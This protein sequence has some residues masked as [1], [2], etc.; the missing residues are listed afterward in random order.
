MQPLP[1]VFGQL[2][3]SRRFSKPDDLFF[4][5]QA[6]F[7]AIWENTSDLT[8]LMAGFGAALVET[9]ARKRPQGRDSW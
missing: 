5:I 3:N 7:R 2:V 6:S 9:D 8:T 4:D 1:W